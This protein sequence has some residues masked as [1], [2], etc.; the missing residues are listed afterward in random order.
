MHVKNISGLHI[1]ALK[2]WR[3]DVFLFGLQLS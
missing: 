3:H 1:C 2:K